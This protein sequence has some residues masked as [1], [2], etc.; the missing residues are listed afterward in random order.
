MQ[1]EYRIIDNS[2]VGLPAM[3]IYGD[4]FNYQ[5]LY[6]LVG[7]NQFMSTF[8]LKAGSVSYN[9]YGNSIVGVIYYDKK[10]LDELENSSTSVMEVTNNKIRIDTPPS[11]KITIEKKKRLKYQGIDIQDIKSISYLAFSREIE[12]HETRE[13]KIP[14]I[15][16]IEANFDG[17]DVDILNQNYLIMKHNRGTKLIPY[18]TEQLVG[19]TLAFNNGRI[20][21]RILNEFGFTEENIKDNFNIWMSFY[22]VKDNRNQL[23][24]VDQK[25]YSEIKDILL[26]E[27]TTKIVKELNVANLSNSSIETSTTV[28]YDI[29]EA[30]KEFSPSILLHGKKQVYW[31]IDS[32][33]HIALRHLKD[34]QFGVFKTKTHFSY[35]AEDLKSLIEQVLGKISAEIEYYFQSN[36]TK[37]FT[38]HGKMAIIYNGDHYHIRIDRQGRLIQ[39]YMAGKNI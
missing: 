25:H 13:K 12:R 34:Y 38:R 10:E 2:N 5:D 27:T 16:E 24:E 33:I 6:K 31:D 7:K 4:K 26:L 19:I 36:E 23:T 18:E 15:I 30:V 3:E 11:E 9:E 29:F 28:I 14:N 39:F 22:K 32:Y 20:D 21:S 35:K 8:E 1:K 17:M 37:D